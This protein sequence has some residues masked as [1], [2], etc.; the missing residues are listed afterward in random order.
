[1]EAPP[2]D[3]T[4]DG[5]PRGP[6]RLVLLGPPGTG[7]TTAIV[8]SWLLP[9]L[10]AGVAPEAV[11]SCSFTRS[12]AGELRDRLG[13]D[14]GLS[15][16][17]L[18]RAGSTVHAEAYRL[19]RASGDAPAVHRRKAPVELEEDADADYSAEPAQRIHEADGGEELALV[20]WDFARQVLASDTFSPAFARVCHEM[21][22]KMSI[23]E[24]QLTIERY[25]AA[26]LK[27]NE[28]DF[29]D[30]LTR[31]LDLEPPE[32][33][34]LIVDE[35]QD[36]T[37]LQWEL[38][39]RWAR[40]ASI[41]VLVGDLDQ[42]IHE[43]CG[44]SPRTIPALLGDTSDAWELR[45]LTQSYRVP[46]RVH[47][48]AKALIARNRNRIE[49]PYLPAEHG[50]S[51]RRGVMAL[52]RK[53]LAEIPGTKRTAFVL[54]RAAR[55]LS[56][57][58][59]ELEAAGIPFANERGYSPL[60]SER[61]LRIARA[62]LA[63]RDGRV[64]AKNDALAL[65]KSLPVRRRGSPESAEWFTR[66]KAKVVQMVALYTDE[67][68]PEDLRGCGV[69][70]RPASATYFVDVL[71]AAG[72]DGRRVLAL[73]KIAALHGRGAFEEDPPVTLTTMHASKGREADLVVVDLECPKVVAREIAMD[74]ATLEAERRILYVALT[75]SK[76][77][78]VIVPAEGRNDLGDLV[79]LPVAR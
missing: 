41:V 53:A 44:A 11:L 5:Y 42:A 43:W 34:L 6:D 1:M 15:D 30:M 39:R 20:V 8:R 12:A 74:A 13:R 9:A 78:L 54:C 77:D 16:R 70:L 76:A 51:L 69:N 40:S 10:R 31:A 28:L 47:G 35:A 75:R 58:A 79:G 29:T 46:R 52:G 56:S 14:T 33:E 38:I 60:G 71:K 48:V 64:L 32:R 50:G 4:R 72:V 18:L 25:E 26:K 27:A 55:F 7:K 73:E 65:V 21:A 67:L 2:F 23:R 36:S 57:W 24:I 49:A 66:D 22:P 19:L 17:E 45:G 62:V 59:H 61:D 37:P 68:S 63:L 3:A